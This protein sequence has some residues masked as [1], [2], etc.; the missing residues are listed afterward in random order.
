MRQPLQAHETGHAQDA[1]HHHCAD[2]IRGSRNARPIE[3][4]PRFEPWA[5]PEEGPQGCGDEEAR[6]LLCGFEKPVPQQAQDHEGLRVGREGRPFGLPRRNGEEFCKGWELCPR[7]G[8]DGANVLPGCSWIN[9]AQCIAGSVGESGISVPLL[10]E[11]LHEPRAPE[12]AARD[13]MLRQNPFRALSPC[14][15]Q[16]PTENR[17][18]VNEL[19][20]AITFDG[21]ALRVGVKLELVVLPTQGATPLG[22]CYPDQGNKVLK[23]FDGRSTLPCQ[24]W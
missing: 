14:P 17:R 8:A 16:G 6:A 12:R 9:A 15:T 2:E 13:E 1:A 22:Y 3:K 21:P 24:V 23:L 11:E 4:S 7:G 10:F 18:D 19:P 5:E 20:N